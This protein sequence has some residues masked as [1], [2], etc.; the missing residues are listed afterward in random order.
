MI[1]TEICEKDYCTGCTACAAACSKGAISI[2]SDS[3]GFLYPE[4]DETLCIN[5][6]LCKKTCPVS[7]YTI[8][9]NTP[10]KVYAAINKDERILNDSSSGGA[11]PA[12]ANYFYQNGGGVV[13]AA[14]DERL[15]LKHIVSFDKRHLS[16]FQG[17]KYVQSSIQNVYNDVM[18]AIKQKKPILFVGTPCQVAGINAVIGNNEYLYT[19][20]LVCH[21]VPSPLLFNKYLQ[22]IRCD[23][24]NQYVDFWFRSKI[25]S[26]YFQHSYKRIN[27]RIQKIPFKKHSFI[28]AYLKGWL[29]RESCYRCPFASIPRQGDCTISDFW[30]IIGRKVSFDR[31]FDNG[32]SM[33]M[34]NTLKGQSLFEQ[35]KDQFYY[36]EKTLDEAKIDNHNLYSHDARP[37]IRDRVYD[38]IMTMQPEKFM[39]KYGLRLPHPQT[40][41]ERVYYKI[42]H[43]LTLNR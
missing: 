11:F 31:T 26:A 28:C 4:V 34:V 27:K 30:G 33:I 15:Q 1:A 2:V 35:I 13:A 32:I 9:D 20:D 23:D 6:G 39:R 8:E 43:L 38:E 5:C 14:F 25:N 22:Q 3:E 37:E 21:G 12:C 41:L 18:V 40:M 36:E 42:T 19:I 10:I 17:S 29:H 7:N 24:K 16:R